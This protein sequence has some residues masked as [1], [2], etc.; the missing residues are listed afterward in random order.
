[1]NS[2][3]AI[4][5]SLLVALPAAQA[6]AE[7]LESADHRQV[8][9][10]DAEGAAKAMFE[11]YRYGGPQEMQRIEE[12]CWSSMKAAGSPTDDGVA[13]CSLMGMAGAFVEAS[14]A[15]QQ[16]RSPAPSY[17][18][19]GVRERIMARTNGMGWG[20]E[21]IQAILVSSVSPRQGEVITGLANAGMR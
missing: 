14:Y 7:G 13:R 21:R 20:Q 6:A 8:Q 12:Q 11:A 15:R 18:G 9:S 4:L 3:S 17:T 16:R 1:M 10:A 5:I 2:Y 19:Q